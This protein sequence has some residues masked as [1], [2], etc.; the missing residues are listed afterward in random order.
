MTC[1]WVHSQ[2]AMDMIKL[3]GFDP[4][5]EDYNDVWGVEIGGNQYAII[6]SQNNIYIVDVTDCYNPVQ[7][8]VLSPPGNSSIWRD[9]K[10]KDGYIY[11]V[12]DNCVE[13]LV[14]IDANVLPVSN[15]V[16]DLQTTDFF[17]RAHNIYIDGDY[18]YAV[19]TDAVSEGMVVLDISTPLS[20]TLMVNIDFDILTNG[21]NTASNYY[22]HDIN[23]TNGIAYAS[24]GYLAEFIAWDVSNL[25]NISQLGSFFTG[26]YTHSSWNTADEKYAYVAEEV[27]NGLPLRVIDL[28]D[29]SG[30][31]SMTQAGTFSHSID[32]GNSTPH[33]PFVKGDT[34]FVSNYQDG[35]KLYDISNPTSPSVLAY[36]DTY[37]TMNYNG[38]EGTWGVYPYLSS[39]CILASDISTGLYVLR[40]AVSVGVEWNDFNVEK[41][42]NAEAVL[43]WSTLQETNSKDFT[44][45]RS[46]D[47]NDFSPLSIIQ[48]KGNSNQLT[49]YSFTD[50]RPS[51][52]KNYYK[53][54]QADFDGEILYSEVKSLTFES[55]PQNLSL[56]PSV[57]NQDYLTI[58]GAAFSKGKSII[59][60]DNSG[61]KCPFKSV[62]TENGIKLD[63]KNRLPAGNYFVHI[64]ENQKVINTLPFIRL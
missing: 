23:V 2:S 48:S 22:I 8:A 14:V 31:I 37:P 4:I 53:I 34:L 20:P 44:I 49:R 52:G 9:F 26:D 54:R 1:G 29:A 38:Y 27:P 62:K 60:L 24:H 18:L 56:Y 47:G 32:P 25:T 40:Y 63:F 17:N 30:N 35:V 12:C 55:K 7:K 19:G 28:L 58:R 6:G 10:T 5:A 42:Q 33:N 43:S 59:I 36:Y 45:L 61:K 41:N 57:L 11:A 13:G 46:K 15:P 3:S 51:S 64:L 39:G 21:V 50:S 16:I